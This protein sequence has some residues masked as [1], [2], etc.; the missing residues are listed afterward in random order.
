MRPRIV[1]NKAS[2]A[3]EAKIAANILCKH[4]RMHLMMEPEFL[5]HLYF[6][7]HV[8]EAVNSGLPFVVGKPKRKIS[9]CVA[10]IANRLG[11]F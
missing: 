7:Q 5:G 11:Y 6:D 8:S 1:V 4:V 3:Y 2:N 9:L 10:D